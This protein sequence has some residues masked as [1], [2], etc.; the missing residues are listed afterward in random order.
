MKK[1]L[2]RKFAGFTLTELLMVVLVL[3]VLA[4]VSVPKMKKVLETRRTTEAEEMLAAV[5]MEQ[6]ARCIAGKTYHKN[7]EK[8]SALASASAS[9]NYEYHLDS[10]GAY[11]LSK[12]ADDVYSIKMLSYSTGQLCCEGDG[13]GSLNKDYP[14][15]ASLSA[16]EDECAAEEE[17]EEDVTEPEPETM[18]GTEAQECTAG[19]V[20]ARKCNGDASSVWAQSRTCSDTCVWGEY[21]ACDF[22]TVEKGNRPSSYVEP[23][24]DGYSG[25][26]RTYTWNCGYELTNDACVAPS[27]DPSTKPAD[28]FA[29]CEANSCGPGLTKPYICDEETGTWKLSGA[30]YWSGRCDYK[31]VAG[32]E[33]C[34]TGGCNQHIYTCENEE[35]V[36]SKRGCPSCTKK[37]ETF[38]ENL[39]V[40]SNLVYDCDEW[41][42]FPSTDYRKVEMQEFYATIPETLQNKYGPTYTSSSNS[43]TC[44]ADGAS[45]Y[46]CSSAILSSCNYSGSYGLYDMYRNSQIA[47]PCTK[48][49]CSCTYN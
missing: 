5:R 3:G 40:P 37:Q 34:E 13:C 42:N 48:I 4:T 26:G 2:K 30:G 36:L 27:C 16:V 45:Y 10:A 29:A 22:C 35:W 46:T 6:E 47:I 1:F 21:G 7:I 49:T 23:C 17:E 14:N 8:V 31:P 11:A 15:C 44:G 28:E 20:Q 32:C 33:P 39:S 19:E 25:E 43:V 38:Y 12:K 41:K 9:K 18:C 24:P